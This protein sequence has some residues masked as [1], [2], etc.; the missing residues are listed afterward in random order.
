MGRD[1][2]PYRWFVWLRDTISFLYNHNNYK[3]RLRVNHAHISSSLKGI[4]NPKILVVRLASLGDIIRSTAIIARLKHEYPS[5]RI[6]YLTSKKNVTLIS[7]NTSID[8]IW[9]LEEI[10]KL[11]EYDWVINMQTPNPPQDFLD[12]FSNYTDILQLISKIPCSV[13]SGRRIGNDGQEEISEANA[14]YCDSE[15]E[16]FLLSAALDVIDRPA[17]LT[18]LSIDKGLA[19]SRDERLSHFGIEPSETIMGIY[20]GGKSSGGHDSGYRTYSVDYVV[21][22]LEYFRGQYK[23]VLIG[24]SQDKSQGEMGILMSYLDQH[25]D[26][27]NLIDRTNLAELVLVIQ[28]MDIMVTCDSSPLHMAIALKTPVVAV[29]VTGSR[30]T[31]GK[32]VGDRYIALDNYPP[33]VKNS[34]AWKYFCSSCGERDT[35]FDCTIAKSRDKFSRISPADI[36]QHVKILLRSER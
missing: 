20:I 27:V 12:G 2:F 14:V 8:K 4:K 9:T 29:F 3:K 10:Q 15:Y 18:N 19:L 31:L 34:Y 35:V 22:L 26:I 23:L 36:D 25:I 21:E 33:C 7:G 28:R 6:E 1:I 24:Q 5:A 32:S 16:E 17:D 11:S 30:F 13:I